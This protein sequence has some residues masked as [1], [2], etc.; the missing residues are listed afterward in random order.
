MCLNCDILNANVTRSKAEV[1]SFFN[2]LALKKIL[3]ARYYPNNPLRFTVNAQ[4]NIDDIIKNFSLDWVCYSETGI[5]AH[6]KAKP[7][8]KHTNGNA[9][10]GFSRRAQRSSSTGGIFQWSTLPHLFPIYV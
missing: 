4:T 8:S 5:P 6:A 3:R 1:L 2:S 9:F 7:V 10:S